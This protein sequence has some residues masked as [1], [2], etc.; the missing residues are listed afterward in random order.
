MTYFM[1]QQIYD[2]LI[3]S[4]V[5]AFVRILENEV[6]QLNMFVVKE[7]KY[8]LQKQNKPNLVRFCRQTMYK[9]NEP[10]VEKKHKE[11]K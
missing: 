8:K 1:N 11:T 4:I 5:N 2:I 7:K 9:T 3:A 6:F 10:M